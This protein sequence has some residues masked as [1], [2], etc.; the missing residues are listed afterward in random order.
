VGEL[1]AEVRA[2]RAERGV[3]ALLLVVADIAEIR[4]LIIFLAPPGR[5][6]KS[7]HFLECL[8]FL[9]VARTPERSS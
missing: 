2:V 8:G 5:C 1:A 9:E 3:E 7:K 4:C 6:A